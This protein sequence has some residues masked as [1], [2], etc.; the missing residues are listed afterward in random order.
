MLT[1]TQIAIYILMLLST[2]IRNEKLDKSIIIKNI[3]ILYECLEILGYKSL[4]TANTIRLPDTEELKNNIE[5]VV[6]KALDKMD[7][8][9]EMANKLY[10]KVINKENLN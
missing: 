6:N 7:K 1:D 8:H 5:R 3:F 4:F 2:E 9:I 10:E